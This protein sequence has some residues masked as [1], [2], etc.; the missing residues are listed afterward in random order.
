M[1]TGGFNPENRRGYQNHPGNPPMSKPSRSSASTAR[2]YLNI[3]PVS[4]L[5][6]R[7]L[8]S[9]KVCF[10]SL[11]LP[12]PIRNIWSSPL[13]SAAASPAGCMQWNPVS[14]LPSVALNGNGF[15]RR[16]R[17]PRQRPAGHRR[18]YRPSLLSARLSTTAVTIMKNTAA[19]R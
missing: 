2:R 1:N 8:A 11:S 16:Y 3:N 12:P 14:R 6:C 5:C 17:F 4:A 15:P 13:K 18:R 10:P 9:A 19:S 7:S